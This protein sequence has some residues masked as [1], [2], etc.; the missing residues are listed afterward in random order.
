VR[1]KAGG[2]AKWLLAYDELVFRYL[3]KVVELLHAAELA[4][5]SKVGAAVNRHTFGTEKRCIT[6]KPIYRTVSL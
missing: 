6:H 2:G 3:K 4:G 1:G 5:L